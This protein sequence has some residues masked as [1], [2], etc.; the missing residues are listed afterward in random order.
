[1]V[2]RMNPNFAADY[3]KD[4]RFEADDEVH[5]YLKL[6]IYNFNNHDSDSSLK[7]LKWIKKVTNAKSI[8]CVLKVKNNTITKNL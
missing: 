2:G 1:M 6:I 8:L 4:R 5:V 3:H 7:K